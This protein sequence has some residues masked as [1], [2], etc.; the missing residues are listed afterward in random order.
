[1]C[2]EG[3]GRSTAGAT[4]LKGYVSFDWGTRDGKR[5][6][7]DERAAAIAKAALKKAGEFRLCNEM[8]GDPPLVTFASVSEYASKRRRSTLALDRQT[9]CSVGKK[10]ENA[11]CTAWGRRLGCAR[12]WG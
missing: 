3:A 11:G 12:G 10:A 5:C 2:A 7:K 6:G 4:S 9:P 8:S 1:M